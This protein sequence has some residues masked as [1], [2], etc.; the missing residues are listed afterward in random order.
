MIIPLVLCH[1]SPKIVMIKES[2]VKNSTNRGGY[3]MMMPTFD[4]LR[5]LVAVLVVSSLN[6]VNAGKSIWPKTIHA[7]M[8]G[9]L[10]S[11]NAML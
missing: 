3:K 9:N 4:T 1:S 5:K 11:L 8:R 7:F 10:E 2:A 6:W